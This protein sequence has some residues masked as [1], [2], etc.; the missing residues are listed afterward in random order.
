MH[1]AELWWASVIFWTDSASMDLITHAIFL[2]PLVCCIHDTSVQSIMQED[3]LFQGGS[4]DGDTST[5][6][7]DSSD[8]ADVS[9]TH[10]IMDICYDMQ[11]PLTADHAR[12][13]LLTEEI[14]IYTLKVTSVSHIGLGVTGVLDR[15]TSNRLGFYLRIVCWLANTIVGKNR[16]KSLGLAPTLDEVNKALKVLHT[17]SAES[18]LAKYKAF[19]FDPLVRKGDTVSFYARDGK[20]SSSPS[21]ATLLRQFYHQ[22]DTMKNIASQDILPFLGSYDGMSMNKA[23]VYSGGGCLA[24][25]H[26]ENAYLHFLHVCL[27]ID[28]AKVDFAAVLQGTMD[29]GWVSVVRD[30]LCSMQKLS[31]K[32]WVCGGNT[33][34]AAGVLQVA[35]LI[36]KEFGLRDCDPEVALSARQYVLNPSYVCRKYPEIFYERKMRP[37]EALLLNESH[38]VLGFTTLSMAWNVCLQQEL[39]NYLQLESKLAGLVDLLP[40]LHAA[41][42]KSMF[43]TRGDTITF[44]LSAEVL[45]AAD[46][47]FGRKVQGTSLLHARLPRGMVDHVYNKILSPSSALLS[48]LYEDQLTYNLPTQAHLGSSLSFDK[49][50]TP[51]ANVVCHICGKPLL[52]KAILADYAFSD[53]AKQL[54]GYPYCMQCYQGLSACIT[55]RA[56]HIKIVSIRS[57]FDVFWREYGAT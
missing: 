11:P 3:I 37:G 44:C 31:L 30:V 27:D 24:G 6:A 23:W 50:I 40:V 43:Q 21:C 38:S 33:D 34:D 55:K 29:M 14:E 48:K 26:I 32:S 41:N 54:A 1:I 9:A 35:N 8:E 12:Q 57:D 28:W 25:H 4:H 51:V 16:V 20:L 10:T 47:M 42:R 45:A 36:K 56:K 52:F 2:A 15:K 49:R 7:G 13:F 46:S 17:E 18:L 19:M 53:K 22:C 39:A 5:Q